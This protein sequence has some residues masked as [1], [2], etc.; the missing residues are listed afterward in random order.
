MTVPNDDPLCLKDLIR[1]S[2]IGRIFLFQYFNLILLWSI[3]NITKEKRSFINWYERTIQYH[4]YPGNTGNT[5]FYLY[6]IDPYRILPFQYISIPDFSHDKY[7]N[8]MDMHIKPS[9]SIQVLQLPIQKLKVNTSYH[10]P[11]FEK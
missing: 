1:S 9:T 4:I 8:P 3:Y 10:S 11:F 2:K 5:G 6:K 7:H